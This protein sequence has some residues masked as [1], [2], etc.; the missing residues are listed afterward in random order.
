MT[1]TM[2]ILGIL[3]I[4][5]I[6]KYN[7]SNKLFWTLFT[8]FTLGFA[9]MKVVADTFS[10]KEQSETT[11]NQAYP[12]QG[13]AAIDGAF[14]LFSEVDFNLAS[15]EVTPNLVSQV[16]TPD[17]VEDV[18]TLSYV[19]GATPGSY[20]HVFPNPPNTL[21]TVNPPNTS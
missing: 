19:H 2:F 8:A 5:C 21:H 12:I 10:E 16:P 18:F 14:A 20:V 17:Y 13:L 15:E 3:I 11:F 9:G 6:A 4:L 1:F 7:E